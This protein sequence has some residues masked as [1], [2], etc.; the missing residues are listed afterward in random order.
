M[1]GVTYR[2]GVKELAYSQGPAL[3]E[4]LR[5]R[6]ARVE[7]YD[8]VLTDH[9]ISGLGAEPWTWGKASDA[10]ILITQQYVTESKGTHKN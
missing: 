5:G 10:R 1:L 9:D 3:I 2:A 8:P 7:A 4:R 6:G